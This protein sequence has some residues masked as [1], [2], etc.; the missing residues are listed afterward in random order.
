MKDFME[1]AQSR[2]S[3][4]KFDKRPI[5]GEKLEKIL[6]AGRIAPTACNYQPQRIYLLQSEDAMSKI[7]AVCRCI[8]GA[9]TCIVVAYDENRGAKGTEELAY[10]GFNFA[11]MDATIVCTHMMLEAWD[12][13]IGSCWVGAFQR[14]RVHDILGLPANETVCALLPIGYPAKES[15]PSNNHYS[16]RDPMETVSIL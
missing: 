15:K 16:L 4:R 2:Y 11:E 8:Y 5:E 3:V 14:K 10:E 12:L 13:G 7:N 9:P 6:E 1:L